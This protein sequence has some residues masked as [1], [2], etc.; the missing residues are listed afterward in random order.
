[1]D[2]TLKSLGI[3]SFLHRDS[4]TP[5]GSCACVIYNN[6]RSLCAYLGAALKY[7]IAHLQ[8]NQAQLDKAALIYSSAFLIT[9]NHH[10]LIH[11]AKHAAKNNIPFAF[12]LSAVFLIQ[13]NLEQIL[14]VLPYTDYVFGNETDR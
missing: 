3:N 1:M 9:S 14:E 11:V 8:Q 13:Y 2:E 4:D 10:A 5:T 6:E 12:N 7:P